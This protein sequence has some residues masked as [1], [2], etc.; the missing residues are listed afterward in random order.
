MEGGGGGSG[1][2]RSCMG[3]AVSGRGWVVVVICGLQR[4]DVVSRFQSFIELFAPGG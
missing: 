3:C 2:Q 1:L 4:Q